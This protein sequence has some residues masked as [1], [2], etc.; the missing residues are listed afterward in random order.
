MKKILSFLAAAGVVCAALSGCVD[1]NQYVVAKGL[2]VG[3]DC[4]PTS[5]DQSYFAGTTCNPSGG[6]VVY[7]YLHIMNYV[8]GKLPWSSAGGGS[9]TT[10]EAEVVNP[11]VIFIDKIMIECRAIDGDHS[12]CNGVDPIEI[13]RNAPVNG[14]GGGY[15]AVV[16][17]DFGTI[18][19]WGGNEITVEVYAKY[20]DS[21][22]IKGETSHVVSTFTF[23]GNA[24]P[25]NEI[26]KDD[27]ETP[28]N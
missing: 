11:G 24:G 27:E 6:G 14:S 25:C 28:A 21:S 23:A 10:F 7:G 16:P 4:N 13:S 9:G 26:T 15:C 17:F 19:S 22:L 3:G 1:D 18:A 2:V 20:H 5:E 12:G 8:T